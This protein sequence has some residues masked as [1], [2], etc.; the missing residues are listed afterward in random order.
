[1]TEE[2]QVKLKKGPTP[3]RTRD[4]EKTSGEEKRV[5]TMTKNFW[6]QDHPEWRKKDMPEI[7][8]KLWGKLG[9]KLVS[10]ELHFEMGCTL[11]H[12]GRLKEGGRQSSGK[13][14]K[15]HL[16]TKKTKR[17]GGRI[18]EL[19]KFKRT[20][21]TWKNPQTGRVKP[22]VAGE[23]VQEEHG[24]LRGKLLT[25]GKLLGPGERF[26]FGKSAS[27]ILTKKGGIVRKGGNFRSFTKG[28]LN[29]KMGKGEQIGL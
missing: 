13:T 25:R 17:K 8:K 23:D 5:R 3:R 21:W 28:K 9:K 10:K 22:G 26:Y 14:I 27:N 11:A 19:G 24:V 4:H 15:N 2:F 20:T 7:C 16:Q 12:Q 29:G 18:R 6:D 1:L